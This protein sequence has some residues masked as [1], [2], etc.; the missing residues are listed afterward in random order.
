MAENPLTAEGKLHGY[1]GVAMH[2]LILTD[3][4]RYPCFRRTSCIRI[5]KLAASVLLSHGTL[6]EV[7]RKW[8]PDATRSYDKGHAKVHQWRSF[9]TCPVDPSINPVRIPLNF[10]NVQE[11]P[12]PKLLREVVEWA[13][14]LRSENVKFD[15]LI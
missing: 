6:D 2:I 5:R 1:M 3:Y 13:K 11:P 9:S 15:R 8:P 14:V 10:I 12:S 4:H 7:S